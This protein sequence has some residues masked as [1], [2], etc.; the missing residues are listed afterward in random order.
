MQNEYKRQMCE[1]I[2]YLLRTCELSVP[3][4]QDGWHIIVPSYSGLAHFDTILGYPIYVVDCL[5]SF[6]FQL[7][8]PVE[9]ESNRKFLKAFTERIQEVVFR[10]DCNYV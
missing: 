5:G 8:I 6:D 3:Y 7:A 10:E 1:Y 2:G 4:N 9:Q